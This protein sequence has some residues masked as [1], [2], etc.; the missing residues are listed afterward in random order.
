MSTQHTQDY[1]FYGCRLRSHVP[2]SLVPRCA[3]Q[4]ETAEVTLRYGE[5]PPA[6]DATVWSNP[7]LSVDSYGAALLQMQTGVRLLLRNGSE[8]VLDETAASEPF[9]VE[10]VL[11][12]TAAGV[13][14]HQRGTLPLH[15]SCVDLG[16]M[17]VA[18]CGPCGRGKSTLAR[19]FVEQG[20]S[21][22]TDDISVVRFSAD[23]LPYVS[24]GSAGIRLWPDSKGALQRSE[25]IWRPIR[26]G[27][28]KQVSISSRI[29]RGARPLAAV[30]RLARTRN[31]APGLDR[32]R[33]PASV[34]PMR[35]LV[36][37]AALGRSMGRR[38]TLFQGLMRLAASTPIYELRRPEGLD[39][40]GEV[41]GWIREAVENFA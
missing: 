23:G 16:G 26:T 6:L 38:E 7:F 24:Q 12:G 41:T 29:A 3:T 22:L 37:R 35:D 27:V 39:R 1:E 19:A 15:A 8:I 31:C 30:V 33:G 11:I 5:V 25:E 21:L 2:L 18:F 36:Y 4:S 14:L 34:M 10:T 28:L 40:L 9:D 17:A 13:L 32:L 20:A